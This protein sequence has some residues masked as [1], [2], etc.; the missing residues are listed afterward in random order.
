MKKLFLLFIPLLLA[1]PSPAA[2]PERVFGWCE[3]GNQTVAITGQPASTTKV[4]RSYPSC[5]I[6]V[7]AA[8][9][10]TLSTIYSDRDSTPL[11]NPFTAASDGSWFFYAD[12]ARYDVKLA[13][14]G[15]VT[16]FTKGDILVPDPRRF[17]PARNCVEYSG[18]DAGAKIQACINDLPSTGGTAD[19]R[20]ITGAQTS[21]V[22]IS[23][24]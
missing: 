4:Q 6:T 5:T 18:S 1:L 3:A 21:S 11:A 15:I 14:G 8:G 22:S 24:G 16:P 17:G 23:I 9:T 12:F 2:Q 19:A 10:L 13:G 7:Y 20:G